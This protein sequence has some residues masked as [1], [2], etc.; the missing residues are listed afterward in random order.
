MLFRT[1]I[2]FCTPSFDLAHLRVARAHGKTH[3]QPIHP[4]K[5]AV[6]A[7]CGRALVLEWPRA[8]ELPAIFSRRRWERSL[9]LIFPKYW[10]TRAWRK[11][12]PASFSSAGQFR[13]MSFH[14]ERS[15]DCR[16]GIHTGCMSI[17]GES[18]LSR[19]LR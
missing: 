17:R 6:V 11:P 12:A 15:P 16:T 9:T 5:D 10:S 13:L 14:Q 18:Q 2:S 1:A 19:V 8:R 3:R 7:S 4:P